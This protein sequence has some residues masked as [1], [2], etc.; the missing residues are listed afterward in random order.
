MLTG[1]GQFLFGKNTV[2]FFNPYDLPALD[3]SRFERIFLLTPEE[4]QGRYGAVFGERLIY[5]QSVTFTLEQ[6]EP[7]SLN[8]NPAWH[9]PKKSTINT[10]NLL[11]Q[12]Y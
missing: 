9:F 3:T 8:N 4:S 5:K 1:P 10:K 11:F 2:Y 7:V 12:V 6:F